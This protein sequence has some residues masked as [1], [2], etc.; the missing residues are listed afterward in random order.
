VLSDH[1]QITVTEEIPLFEQLTHAGFPTNAHGSDEPL[2]L[3]VAGAMGEL[4]LRSGD[5]RDRDR[6]VAWLQEQPSISHL[7]TA[8]LNGMD[9]VTPGTLSMRLVGL[10]HGRA[11]DIVFTLRSHAGPDQYGLPGTGLFMGGVPLRG[12]MHGGLNA[13]ELST[14]LILGGPGVQTGARLDGP[15][16]LID[17]APTVLAVLGLDAPPT[18]VGQPLVSAFGAPDPPWREIVAHANRGGYAQE[19]RLRRSSGASYIIEGTAGSPPSDT[20]RN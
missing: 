1:G 18:M 19:V 9:G 16:G 20:S 13:H 15:A 4:R 12:G 11:P 10:D 5:G 2:L 14:V 17:I 7:F 6:V 8:D 3:G